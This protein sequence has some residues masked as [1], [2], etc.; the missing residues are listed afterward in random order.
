MTAPDAVPLAA[1]V[2]ELERTLAVLPPLP[3]SVVGSSYSRSTY[4]C[5]GADVVFDDGSA[6]GEHGEECPRDRQERIVAAVNALPALLDAARKVLRYEEA[7]R[8]IAAYGEGAV[9]TGSFDCPWHAREAR[10][11]M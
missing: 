11:A 3:W 2:E 9:V 10:A 5:G 1:L 6:G 4:V 7:L 8:G